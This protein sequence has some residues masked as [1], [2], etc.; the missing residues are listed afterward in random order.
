MSTKVDNILQQMKELTDAVKGAG[1]PKVDLNWDMVQETFGEQIKAL[2]AAQVEEKMAS[3][4]Q[5]R[6]P[7]A[8]VGYSDE[9]ATVSKE[10]RYY[11]YLK[12]IAKDGYARVGNQR[13]KA[14]DLAL[15]HA[16]L[17]KAHT[18]M[19]DR[20]TL[21][22]EELAEAV[23]ALSSTGTGTG[24]E[25]V[26]TGM[27]AELWDDI[28]LASRVVASMTTVEMPTNPFDVPLGLGDV[29]WYKGQENT[30][31]TATDTATDK[32]TLTATE[33]AAEV[34]WSYTLQE[35][36]VIALMP[37]VRARLAISGAEV[38][39]AFALNADSTNALNGNI[40]LNDGTPSGN[41]YY[42]TDGQDGIR[43]LFLVDNTAQG[44]DA[45]GALGD[46]AITSALSKMG[47][48][49]V[50][51]DQVVMVCDSSTYLNGFLALSNVTTV[52]KFG[53]QAAVLTGQLAAYRGVPIVVSASMGLT[54]AAGT[55]SGTAS[56]NTKGQ[57]AIIN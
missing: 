13:V 43:H 7:G 51:P 8:A 28:F 41:E 50:N 52:D 23:K 10:N 33:L 9:L 29:N 17:S 47:K 35:D 53:P 45:A 14:V 32:S 49:A 31:A 3:Q 55:I 48:Y 25:L 26:P 19:P 11:R 6:I 21:P 42:L 12:G 54:G 46:S 24:D 1:N 4:P 37:A 40:N 57:V 2:V 39:D 18:L 20:V 30:A 27:A 22:S 56:N 38:V 5:R 34:D 16:L 44:V 15:T 36:A